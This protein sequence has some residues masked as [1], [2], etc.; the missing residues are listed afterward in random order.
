MPPRAAALRDAIL[1]GAPR[2]RLWSAA[3]GQANILAIIPAHAPG[4]GTPGRGAACSRPELS[5]PARAG[6]YPRADD[7]CEPQAGGIC[8]RH[9]GRP[10]TTRRCAPSPACSPHGLPAHGPS[11]ASL[12]PRAPLAPS[13]KP[14]KRRGELVRAI[15]ASQFRAPPQ[16]P[17]VDIALVVRRYAPRHSLGHTRDVV[18]LD[19]VVASPPSCSSSQSHSTG[20]RTRCRLTSPSRRHAP[21]SPQHSSSTPFWHLPAPKLNRPLR[22]VAALPVQ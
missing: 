7:E 6:R 15:M 19:D 18:Q 13:G 1:L 8:S 9:R 11:S 20:T 17:A 16:A 22:R 10:R 21:R 14:S 4:R 3:Q 2:V 5:R 12:D